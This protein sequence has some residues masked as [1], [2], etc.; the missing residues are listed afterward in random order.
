[1]CIKNDEKLK[2]ILSELGPFANHHA[3][4]GHEKYRIILSHYIDPRILIEFYLRNFFDFTFYY[5]LWVLL[6]TSGSINALILVTM[7][8]QRNFVMT[9]NPIF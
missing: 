4:D 9:K 2:K 7:M 3:N 1:V 8:L 6:V 5:I